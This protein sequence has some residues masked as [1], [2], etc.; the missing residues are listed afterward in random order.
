MFRRQRDLEALGGGRRTAAA[1]EDERGGHRRRAGAAEPGA[2]CEYRSFHKASVP[3]SVGSAFRLQHNPLPPR[4]G[5][6]DRGCATSS[7]AGRRPAPRPGPPRK[8]EG[9][10]PGSLWGAEAELGERGD[11]RTDDWEGL[12][13]AAQQ[14]DRAAYA[15]F[16]AAIL[17]FA[18]AIARR[19]LDTPEAVED[20]VQDALLTLHRVRHTY[21]PELPVRPWLAAIVD[22][23]A[24][25]ALRRRTR[26][27]RVEI[28][29]ETAAETFADAGAKPD[30]TVEAH[31][32]VGRMMTE[33][34]PGQ[35]EAIE[36][37]K[38]KEM[39]LVEASAASGQSI[40]LLKVNVH[41]GIK[42]LRR[43]FV[44]ESGQ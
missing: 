28:A 12:L 23:R 13:A 20:A 39:S 19:R 18:R 41:R 29:D 14:G 30:V 32:M 31:D 5:E 36:L 25:D 38:L 40:A 16:L 10:N 2:A 9:A 11:R 15:Q 7:R 21:R 33:L 3:A 26:T 43:L 44:E 34:T 8:G 27:R 37:V 35:R 24:V 4:G 22:R 42:R 6:P 1:G 17:P